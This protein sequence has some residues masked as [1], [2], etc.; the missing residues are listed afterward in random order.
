MSYDYDSYLK[1]TVKS[2]ADNKTVPVFVNHA[3]GV[4]WYVSVLSN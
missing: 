4:K 2:L 3:D 1:F